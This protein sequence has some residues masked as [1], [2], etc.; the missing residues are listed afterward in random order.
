MKAYE[1]KMNCALDF[2]IRRL[3]CLILFM[4][5]LKK[6]QRTLRFN[7]SIVPCNLYNVSIVTCSVYDVS[8]ARCN[9]YDISIVTCSLYALTRE[10]CTSIQHFGAERSLL[11]I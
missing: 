7:A 11:C 5:L 2:V 6:I 1:L 10:L 9:V 8:I 4:Q 3:A